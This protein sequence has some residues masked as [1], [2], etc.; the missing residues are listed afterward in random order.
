MLT[1]AAKWMQEDE[2]ADSLSRDLSKMSFGD[3][4]LQIK[5]WDVPEDE[6]DPEIRTILDALPLAKEQDFQELAWLFMDLDDGAHYRTFV[7]L[8]KEYDYFLE[9]EDVL[10]EIE[11][12]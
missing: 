9:C 5:C 3:Y 11:Q 12:V 10:V 7:E 1:E 6:I 4:I 2:P 8:W